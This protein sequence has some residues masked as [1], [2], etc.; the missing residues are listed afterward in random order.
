MTTSDILERQVFQA[1]R[2]LIS[3][4]EM[5][6][7]AYI[8]QSGE[9]VSY[10]IE[11][12]QRIDLEEFGKGDLIGEANLVSDYPHFINYEA[13]TGTT[14]VKVNRQDFEKKMKKHDP[15]VKNILKNMVDKIQKHDKRWTD[16]VIKTKYEDIKATKIVDHL[17][18]G[19]EEER[20]EKYREI[21]LPQFSV[22]IKAIEEL[23]AQERS[24][25]E[26]EKNNAD[27]HLLAETVSA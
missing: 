1:G 18:S 20:R 4:D 16:H 21:L 9:V 23:K 26:L 25:K 19:M 8:I 11:N 24:K 27:D 3:E 12:G 7:E 15:I 17:L 2:R 10:I 6:P 14:V 5:K 13:I 22:M